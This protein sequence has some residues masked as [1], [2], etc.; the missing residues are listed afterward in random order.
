[1]SR[2]RYYTPANRS[3]CLCFECRTAIADTWADEDYG[4]IA[5]E[6]YGEFIKQLERETAGDTPSLP[7]VQE[8]G[9]PGDISDSYILLLMQN[10]DSIDERDNNNKAGGTGDEVDDTDCTLCGT[11]RSDV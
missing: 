9:C 8:L 5:L 3:T 2:Y 7:D 1:M 10:E 4:V 6:P 11:E